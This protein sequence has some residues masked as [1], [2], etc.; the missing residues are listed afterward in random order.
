[1]KLGVTRAFPLY[2]RVWKLDIY[3]APYQKYRSE[4]VHGGKIRKLV[5][6]RGNRLGA[7][8]SGIKT[9]VKQ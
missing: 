9:P 8:D 2:N 3:L 6:I 7:I 4:S 1:M 5:G